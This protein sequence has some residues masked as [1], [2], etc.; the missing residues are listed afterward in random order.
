MSKKMKRCAAMRP[1]PGDGCLDP[2]QPL[3]PRILGFFW[4]S[5]VGELLGSHIDIVVPC[6]EIDRIFLTPP[7]LGPWP[8]NSQCQRKVQVEGLQAFTGYVI[9]R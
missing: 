2:N 9:L 7:G 8:F 6:D 3:P 5:V 4:I 1:G